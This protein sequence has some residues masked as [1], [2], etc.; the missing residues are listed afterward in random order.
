MSPESIASLK[1]A[2]QRAD[3]VVVGAGA[4]L[5][6]AAG[7]TYDGKRFE[8]FFG[9]FEQKYGFHDMYAGGFY[10]Y[11]T[12]EELWAFWSR[13][14]FINRYDQPESRVYPELLSLVKDKEYFVLTTNV[15]HAFQLAGFDKD[16]LF[17]TQGDY[18]LFQCARPCHQKTYDNA[19]LV[20]KMFAEQ[21]D[22]KIP[23]ALIP[24]CP[25]C[26]GPMMMNLR[27]DHR[28]VEDAG[29]RLAAGRW[30][31]FLDRRQGAYILF[32]EL[33]VGYNSPGVIKIPFQRMTVQNPR[34]VYACVNLDDTRIPREL[35]DRSLCIR[36]DLAEVLHALI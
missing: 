18:G 6:A 7:M 20:Y 24:K 3:A 22:M 36:S 16:R 5:S 12:Q 33:G 32:W 11:K 13:N 8:T 27:I 4:G 9:D 28:F 14:I 17:Y 31:A 19:D 34:A 2:I 35:T 26:G 1:D 15:D 30:E 10:P 23:S 21:K 29:W 25:V